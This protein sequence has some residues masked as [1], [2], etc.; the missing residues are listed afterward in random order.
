MLSEVY[1]WIFRGCFW[2]SWQWLWLWLCCCCCWW[3]WWWWWLLVFCCGPCF[4]GGGGGVFLG[5]RRRRSH[6]RPKLTHRSLRQK[7]L[8]KHRTKLPSW[9]WTWPCHQMQFTVSKNQK[10]TSYIHLVNMAVSPNPI[11]DKT[12]NFQNYH[13]EGEHGHV[14]KCNLRWVRTKLQIVVGDVFA[15]SNSILLFTTCNLRYKT[16]TS[17][18]TVNP[19]CFVGDVF[20]GSKTILL[21]TTCNLRYKT[22]TSK[23]TVNPFLAFARKRM[24]Q[25]NTP[26][27]P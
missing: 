17:K 1:I 16:N 5:R 24:Y 14:T 9:G 10:K 25:K 7:P 8:P 13:L 6:R 11:E 23:I 18:L 19:S 26:Q 22:N 2:L 27:K 21:F 4:D 12:T 20:A 15:R 3:W